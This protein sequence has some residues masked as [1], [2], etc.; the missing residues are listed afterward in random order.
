MMDLGVP[1]TFYCIEYIAK[2][3]KILNSNVKLRG[4]MRYFAIFSKFVRGTKKFE[5]QKM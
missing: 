5:K 2:K 1:L 4:P 3:L